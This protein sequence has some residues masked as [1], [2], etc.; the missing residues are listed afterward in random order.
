MRHP[1]LAA[2]LP[3]LAGAACSAGH[4][5]GA[6]PFPLGGRFRADQVARR[7]TTLIDGPAW[8]TYCPSD[9]A[10]VIVALSRTWSGG[11]A[12]RTFPLAGPPRDFRVQLALGD[13]GTATAAFRAPDAG[14]ARVGESGSIRVTVS[15][16][17]SGRFEAALPDSGRQHVVIRGTFASIPVS[18]LRAATCAPL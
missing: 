3:V 7:T 6:S 9:S 13:L 11:L 2:A 15:G 18:V 14:P 5:A 4:G 17:V 10:L 16:T 8:A 1:L 12:V